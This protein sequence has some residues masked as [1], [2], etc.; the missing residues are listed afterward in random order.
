[1][2]GKTKTPYEYIKNGINY[3]EK[4]TNSY[5]EP[6]LN[7]YIKELEGLHY[8]RC[9]IDYFCYIIEK[10]MKNAKFDKNDTIDNVIFYFNNKNRILISFENKFINFMKQK[11]IENFEFIKNFLNSF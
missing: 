2:F 7:K 1:M 11:D 6:Y 4:N 8:P 9:F 10:H 5:I 3:V